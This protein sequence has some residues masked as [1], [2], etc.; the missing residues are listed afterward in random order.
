VY[1]SPT[2]ARP[3]CSAAVGPAKFLKSV[4]GRVGVKAHLVPNPER[5]AAE[6]VTMCLSEVRAVGHI[7]AHKC[8]LASVGATSKGQA[9]LQGCNQGV[10]VV[11]VR[12]S[13]GMADM[14]RR[15]KCR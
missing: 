15:C 12:E 10:L 5:C 2:R 9:D 7:C 8:D 11:I 3:D 14:Q 13:A 4:A 6:S 1:L